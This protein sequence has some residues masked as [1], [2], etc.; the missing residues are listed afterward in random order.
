MSEGTGGVPE[1]PRTWPPGADQAPASAEREE[2]DWPPEAGGPDEAGRPEAAASPED[3]SA[4][5]IAELEDRWRRALADLDNFR[6]RTAT[7][8]DRER[9]EERART[10]AAWLPVLDDLERALEHADAEPGAVVQGVRSVLDHARQVIEHLGYPRCDDEGEPFDPARH[11]AVATVPDTG[12]ADG[13]VVRVL[14]PGY[15]HGPA[16]LRPAQVVVAKGAPD[17]PA[18]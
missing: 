9:A 6:K 13:T 12:A 15:G 8:L 18:P 16:Q 11:E 4:V 17:G 3:V 10:T 7:A 1:E 14:R 2:A 5:K